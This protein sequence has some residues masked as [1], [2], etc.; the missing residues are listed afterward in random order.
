MTPQTKRAYLR[1]LVLQRG[2]IVMGRVTRSPA[3]ITI[4]NAC[5]IRRWGTTA[6]LG[7]LAREGKQT[8]TIL[9]PCGTVHVH[10][11][12]VVMEIEC[13]PSRWPHA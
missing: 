10:P 6:G 1:I 7:Q 8:E 4:A 5:V 13:D 3:D 9:D 12:A 2:W 11:L